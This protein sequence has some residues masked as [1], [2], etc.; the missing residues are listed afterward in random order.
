MRINA[1]G[2]SMGYDLS[3]EGDC[4][5]LVHGAGD[6]RWM[7]WEQVPVLSRRFRLLTYDVR[8]FG[9][10]ELGEGEVS[11]GLLGEDLHQLLKALGIGSAY[12]LGY[13]MGGRIGLQAT[14]AYPQ[15]VKALVLANSGVGATPPSPE[16]Q[17]RRKRL[18]GL[19]E[20]G[21]IEAVSEEMT[22][23]SFSPGLKERDPARF[24]RYKA[25]KLR[26]DP[27]QF[28]RVWGA[29][30]AASPPNLSRLNCPVLVIAG[31]HDSF[32]PLAAAK[33]THAAIVGSRLEVLPTGHAAAIEAPGEFNRIVI[34]FLTG[35]ARGGG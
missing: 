8:G 6:N 2:I 3:G 4:L 33:S 32:M 21:N 28:A 26:N 27:H 13:S 25:M 23:L 9:E 12:V 1:N 31:E 17:E 29:L 19:L 5:V 10:S 11:M 15:A 22:K 7:W 34:D 35:P 16:A 14:L 20:Q 18:I 24:G 30:A